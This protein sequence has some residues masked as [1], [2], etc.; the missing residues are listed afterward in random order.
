MHVS[1]SYGM[2]FAPRMPNGSS[3]GVRRMGHLASRPSVDDT[4]YHF[5]ALA[6][7]SRDTRGEQDALASVDQNAAVNEVGLNENGHGAVGRAILGLPHSPIIDV[8]QC[9]PHPT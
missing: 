5:S 9:V 7:G 8:L 4:H 1:R 6:K 3:A 2:T